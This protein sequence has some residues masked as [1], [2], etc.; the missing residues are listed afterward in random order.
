MSNNREYRRIVL[1]SNHWRSDRRRLTS[2]ITFTL[3]VTLG[4][5]ILI[6]LGWGA[7]SD[8]DLIAALFNPIFKSDVSPR[9]LIILWE[10]RM[11]RVLLA[12]LVG[13]SLA[14]SGAILQGLFR[15]PLADPGIVGVSAGAGMGAVIAIVLGNLLPIFVRNLLGAY[16]VPLFAFTFAWLSTILLY[17]VATRHGRTSVATM[18]LAGIALGALSGAITG[19]LVYTADDNQLRDITFWGMGSI[20]AATWGKLIT[21][22]PMI[23]IA[24]LFAPFIAKSLNAL[25]LGEASAQHLGINVQ[26]MKRFSILLVAVSVGASVAVTGG[27]GFV[28]I[29]VPH[30]LRLIQG[31]EHKG[32]FINAALLGAIMLILA[33]AVSRTIISPAELPIGIITAIIGGPFFIWILLRNRGVIDL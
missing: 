31:P 5:C 24:L 21:A 17:R 15:N 12:S 27:I 3:S 11:P 30:L 8:V 2:I 9:D 4:F 19:I 29:V 13:A 33:D 25:T 32:L 7:A 6:S 23:I 22:G 20:A 26:F 1:I 18:L 10:I 14:V 16:L 28:G